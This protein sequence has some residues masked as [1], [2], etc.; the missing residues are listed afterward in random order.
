MIVFQAA[1]AE[2]SHLRTRLGVFRVP[3]GLKKE[4]GVPG[5]EGGGGAHA[6]R[7]FGG[8][9]QFRDGGLV[10]LLRIPADPGSLPRSCQ[11]LT[12]LHLQGLKQWGLGL[13]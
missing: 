13:R 11:I 8:K 6:F 1:G 2:F 9:S 7:V 4:T 3:I 12:A 5:V 10:S